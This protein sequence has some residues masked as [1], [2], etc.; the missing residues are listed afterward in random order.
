V[1]KASALAYVANAAARSLSTRKSGLAGVVV[2]DAAD[3]IVLQMLGAAER[4]LSAHDL[5][6][7]IRVASATAPPGDCAR[8]LVASGVDGLLFVGNA[9]GLAAAARRGSRAIPWAD[10]GPK[11]GSSEATLAGDSIERRGVELALDYLAQLG[12]WQVGVVRQPYGVSGE[13]RIRARPGMT[14]VERQLEHFHDI[15]A[16]RSAV[17]ILIEEG[18][19]AV[20]LL[21]DIAAAA[22]LCECRAL[23][24][25]V[26]GQ[27]SVIGWGDS[28]LA[29]CLAP[30]LTS[31]RVP[32]WS[33]GRA[34]AERLIAAMAGRDFEGPELALKLVIRASTGPRK[35]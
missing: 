31:V 3:P 30:Q 7:L 14:I 32:A 20:V 18:T 15:G 33:S 25:A 1:E 6:V 35:T 19:T 11:P 10:C 5:G 13:W 34:A 9:P 27:I 12:H 8:A 22:A 4:A 21:A 23:D 26:P 24:L 16:I 28:A 2:C 17:R 29:R